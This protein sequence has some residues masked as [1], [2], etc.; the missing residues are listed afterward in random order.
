MHTSSPQQV[1]R[2]RPLRARAGFLGVGHHV[3]WSQFRGLLDEMHR[4]LD[5]VKSR[6]ESNGIEVVAFGMLDTAQC[7]YDAVPKIRAADIDIL[8]VDMVTYGTSSTFGVLCREI[9]VP[10]V[11]VAIQPCASMD[12]ENGTT[13]TQLVNDDFCAV[14]EFTGVAVRFG[15]RAPPVILGHEQ[16]D[17]IV[18]QDLAKWCQIA[19]VLHDLRCSRIGLMGH[20][21]E[22]MLDMHTD[23]TAISAA[24]GPHVVMIE[25]DD[26]LKHYRSADQAAVGK[27]KQR[28]LEFFDTPDPRTDPLTE[29]LTAQ[30]LETAA[31]AAVALEGL[32][33]ERK[34]DGLAY[35]YEGEPGAD[36]R[37]IVTNL[38]AGN[39][40]LTSAGFPMCGEFD[41]KN[42]IA[43]LIMDRLDIGGSF[44]E[45]HPV[46]F[47]RDSVLVGHDG[48]H[49][50]N[51]AA[52]KPVI[53]SLKKYHGKPGS[54]ASVEF[55]I[56]EGPI[57]MLS[58]GQNA[59]G[60]FKFVI[61]EGE[62]ARRP[63]PATGNTN[64]HGIFKPDVRTFLKRWV[65]EGPTHHFALGVG[66]HAPELVEIAKILNL[67]YVQVA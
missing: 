14:P 58:I 43:M 22:S 21:L 5:Y 33:A 39:S 26:I 13:F 15:R 64:T 66:H 11:L 25:P 38:I 30:D 35:Y 9:H 3:Y 17:P 51:I 45:F 6:I 57:T 49:H 7:A 36:L 63:V 53:R 20:V 12:Y 44:S 54:G 37:I 28:I 16:N 62:S 55:Q 31:R 40:L 60:K 29:K 10:I 24:F 4:K 52:T 27:W 65:A 41:L 34:I 61:A 42:C 50:I 2:L 32:I 67:D 48:P 1:T 47:S 18:E 59:D 19:K 8:F 23:P 46:D 56:K